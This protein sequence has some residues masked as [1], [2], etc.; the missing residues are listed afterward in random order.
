[1]TNYKKEYG[2]EKNLAQWS[3]DKKILNTRSTVTY[4]NQDVGFTE[5]YSLSDKGLVLTILK[6]DIIP[7]SKSLKMIFKKKM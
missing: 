4:G 7:E 1:V 6:T 3:A 5:A 2:T